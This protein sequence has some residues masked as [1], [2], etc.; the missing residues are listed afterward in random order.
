M[1]EP[2]GKAPGSVAHAFRNRLFWEWADQ[3][4]RA[5]PAGFIATL[6]AM[7]SACDPGGSV[8]F[9]KGRPITIR[10][11]ASGA[12]VDIKDAR[13]Y[14]NAAIAAGVVAVEGERTSGRAVVYCLLLP[15]HPDWGAAESMLKA[16]RRERPANGK[17]PWAGPD[18]GGPTPQV[19]DTNLG[20]PTP[21]VEQDPGE[22]G[23]GTYPPGTWGDLP[24]RGWGDLPPTIPGSSMTLP[25]TVA[26]VVPQP[27][28][29]PS[30]ALRK[31]IESRGEI[32]WQ[33]AAARCSVCF[34][35]MVMRH[36]RTA[37]AH[38]QG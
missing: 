22:R 11:I 6:Y 37:H 28:V 2:D 20:G 23:G 29:V 4:P 25:M 30:V 36:G 16:T 12:R 1:D 5:V 27:Q 9:N 35:Q 15:P 32:G 31:T 17:A 38:C 19:G 7:A 33:D 18:L 24:P 26:E 21:Q 13:R 10:K 8:R 34:K 3:I 14:V